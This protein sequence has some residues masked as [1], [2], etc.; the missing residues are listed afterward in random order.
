MT[1]KIQLDRAD[2][3]H[4]PGD[5]VSGTVEWAFPEPPFSASVVLRR[6][7]EGKGSFETHVA[8]AE[9]F[10]AIRA[11]GRRDFRLTLPNMPCSFSGSILSIVWRVEFV[12]RTSNWR[13]E[14]VEVFRVVTMSPTGEAIDPYRK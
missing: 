3:R 4:Y 11:V 1:A 5:V 8:S 14:K 6:R 9:D 7:T 2:A 12:V 10:D 13:G